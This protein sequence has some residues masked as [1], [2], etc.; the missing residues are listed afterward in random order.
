MVEQTVE[1]LQDTISEEQ[2]QKD[3][4]FVKKLTPRARTWF[5][6]ALGLHDNPCYGFCGYD[7]DTSHSISLF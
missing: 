2:E 4:N 7:S 5:L 3:E 6:V 1:E